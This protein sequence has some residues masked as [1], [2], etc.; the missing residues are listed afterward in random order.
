[1]LQI[2]FIGPIFWLWT[3]KLSG[4][5][6]LSKFGSYR[7]LQLVTLSTRNK[8]ISALLL[9]HGL[10]VVDCCIYYLLAG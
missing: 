10:H 8:Q 9:G 3:G 5:I 6:D 2:D 4:S 7:H 1:M